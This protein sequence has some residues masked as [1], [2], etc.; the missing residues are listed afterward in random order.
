MSAPA[1]R[2]IDF[3]S[4]CNR[5]QQEAGTIIAGP[6]K[7][8][9]PQRKL[10]CNECVDQA[11]MLLAAPKGTVAAGSAG[12]R[13]LVEIRGEEPVCSFCCR[14]LPGVQRLLAGANDACICQSCVALCVD[15][16]ADAR[17]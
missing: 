4:F 17:A 8:G 9:S 16:N 15:I 12:A 2:R 11:R 1:Q 6:G 5:S 13:T 3:C 14:R 7:V 10:I